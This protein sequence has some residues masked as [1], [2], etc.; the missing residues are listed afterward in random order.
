MLQ[1][2]NVA[3]RSVAVIDAGNRRG[4]LLMCQS[5]GTCLPATC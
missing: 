2:V 3:R 5:D 1:Q 4:L